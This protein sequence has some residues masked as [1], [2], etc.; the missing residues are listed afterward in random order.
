[1]NDPEP[2]VL[3]DS[4]G[5]ATVNLKVYYWIDGHRYSVAKVK[6]AVLRLIKKAMTDAGITSPDEAREVIFPQG[7][8]ILQ[9]EGSAERT[10]M[11]MAEHD[12]SETARAEMQ[13]PES[14]E[15]ATT[16]EG[17]LA[18]ERRDIEAQTA[19][20]DPIEGEQDL[21]KQST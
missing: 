12:I 3:V 19:L 20:V 7:V 2:L 9:L 10:A 6:S 17:D 1:M 5:A 8:P 18:N 13:S 4:L 14:E 15:E 21:L 11:R 16:S